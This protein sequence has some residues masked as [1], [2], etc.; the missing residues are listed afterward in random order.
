MASG[1]FGT[2]TINNNII[3]LDTDYDAISYMYNLND[4]SISNITTN[5]VAVSSNAILY[6][7]F[8]NF[9]SDGDNRFNTFMFATIID[10]KICFI[11][12][13]GNITWASLSNLTAYVYIGANSIRIKNTFTVDINSDVKPINTSGKGVLRNSNNSY[14]I[15]LNDSKSQIIFSKSIGYF[16]P[17]NNTGISDTVIDISSST[18][19]VVYSNI[20]SSGLIGIYYNSAYYALDISGEISRLLINN[21]SVGRLYRY[22]DFLFADQFYI[23]SIEHPDNVTIEIE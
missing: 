18:I 6:C 21:A 19:A 20:T 3:T 14:S 12:E 7:I 10:N 15:E 23:C 2:L 1:F 11:N 13:Y 17:G 9:E 16:E 4:N 22:I 8:N 5:T